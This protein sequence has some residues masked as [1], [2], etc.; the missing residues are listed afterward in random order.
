MLC[1]RGW[2]EIMFTKLRNLYYKIKYSN[3]K[4]DSGAVGIIIGSNDSKDD[5][6]IK[7][8]EL[9]ERTLPCYK[10]NTEVL[11]HIKEKYNLTPVTLSKSAVANYKVNYILNVCPEVLNT[12]EYKLPQGKKAPTCKQIEMLRENSNRRFSEAF[13]Y[14]IEKLGLELECYSFSHQLSDGSEIIFKIVSDKTHDQLTLS[15]SVNRSVT[16]DE[17]MIISNIHNEIDIFKGVTKEDIDN[18]TNRF[19]GYAMAVVELE[20]NKE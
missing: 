1:S 13:N 16:P 15:S 14:P 6:N 8:E 4:S 19:L 18:R 5:F 7:L 3:L 11:N 10:S 12:H 2:G 20:K 9:A 17:Q